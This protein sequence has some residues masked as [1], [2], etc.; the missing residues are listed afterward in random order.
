VLS[1]SIVKRSCKP[2]SPRLDPLTLRIR[3]RL[4]AAM[5]HHGMTQI[6]LVRRSGATPQAV[7]RFLAGQ[8]PYP[9]LSFLDQLARV[10]GW[11]LLEMLADEIAPIPTLTLSPRVRALA[12]QFEAVNDVRVVQAAAAW[13]ETLTAAKPSRGS[14]AGSGRGRPPAVAST[15]APRGGRR[16]TSRS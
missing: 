1:G 11:T 5:K 3:E 13:V 14:S 4:Q 15:P 6:E 9:P 2:V 8:S 16:R 7:Q 10:F 12:A